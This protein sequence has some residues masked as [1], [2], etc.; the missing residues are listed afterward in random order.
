MHYDVF[1]GD[2][3]GV[4]ALLQ[5]RLA[6][7]KTSTLITGVKRNIKLL[8]SLN[9]QASDSVTVLDISMEKNKTSLEAMLAAGAQVFYAD[10]HKSGDIHQHT[11]LDAHINLDANTCTL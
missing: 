10:H 6:E 1:N 5:L 4:I 8:D 2:A 3:D 9:C 11:S 7:P